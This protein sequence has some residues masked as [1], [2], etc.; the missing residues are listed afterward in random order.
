MEDVP[1]NAKSL[2]GGLVLSSPEHVRSSVGAVGCRKGEVSTEAKKAKKRKKRTAKLSCRPLRVRLPRTGQTRTKIRLKSVRRRVGEHIPDTVGAEDVGKGDHREELGEEERVSKKEGEGEREG[3][4]VFLQ[5]LEFVRPMLLSR[6][7]LWKEKVSIG[8]KGKARRTNFD[9]VRSSAVVGAAEVGSAEAAKEVVARCRVNVATVIIGDLDFLV[10]EGVG[11]PLRR[12]LG[13]RTARDLAD[14]DRLAH[15]PHLEVDGLGERGEGNGV[16]RAGVDVVRCEVRRVAEL[17]TEVVVG[18]LVGSGELTTAIPLSNG[19]RERL[20]GDLVEGGERD[21]LR[22][23]VNLGAGRILTAL[24]GDALAT[25]SD[26]G[27][28]TDE[29]LPKPFAPLHGDEGVEAELASDATT[30]LAHELAAESGGVAGIAEG[31]RREVA[32]DLNR[33]RVV[34]QLQLGFEDGGET[35]RRPRLEKLRVV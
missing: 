7:V 11:E 4:H 24:L 27:A 30:V 28:G 23:T 5:L 26:V 32:T 12:V 29:R 3:T 1:A 14:V 19:S 31:M 21:E 25:T 6:E 10:C 8:G 15:A 17:A 13:H 9:A 18:L 2:A 34:G 16:G 20:E 35:R 22:A 33:F